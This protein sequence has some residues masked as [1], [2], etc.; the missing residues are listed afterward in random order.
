MGR[1]EIDWQDIRIEYSTKRES[2][3]NR[4]G[5]VYRRPRVSEGGV[6]YIPTPSIPNPNRFS[7]G[8]NLS[9]TAFPAILVSLCTRRET[10]GINALWRV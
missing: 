7:V 3:H 1:V 6:L 9:F 8:E 4:L 10:E 5:C 2:H